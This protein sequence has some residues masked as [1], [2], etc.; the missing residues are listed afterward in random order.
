MLKVI[1][2]EDHNIVRNGIRMLLENEPDFE[3]IGEATNGKEVLELLEG[4]VEAGL[5]LADI[6]MPVMDGMSMLKAIRTNYPDV[7][8]IFL[9]MLDNEKYISQAFREG[10]SGYVFKNVSSDELIFSLKQ[11][12]SGSRY[13]CTELALNLL[14]RSLQE[15]PVFTTAPE[16]KI[17][18]SQREVE[19]LQLIAEGLTNTEIAEKIFI[20]KRTVEGHRQSILEKTGSKNTATLIRFAVLNGFIS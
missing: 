17:E 6:N 2:A 15:N 8:V 16:S 14:D 12:H 13:L 10:A 7:K 18:F 1:L 3:V 11:V 9:S 4:N 20:S 19:V 5:I